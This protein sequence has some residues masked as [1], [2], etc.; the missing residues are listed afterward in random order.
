MTEMQWE[1]GRCLH[2]LRKALW[3]ALNCGPFFYV[4]NSDALGPVGLEI[5]IVY[6]ADAFYC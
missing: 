3:G 5:I 1:G 2:I 4:S 6:K